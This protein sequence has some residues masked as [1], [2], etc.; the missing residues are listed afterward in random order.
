MR[1][2]GRD[3]IHFGQRKL[4]LLRQCRKMRRRQVTVAVL[5][6]PLRAILAREAWFQGQADK[7]VRMIVWLA[8][9]GH[10][11]A[12][13]ICLKHALPAGRGPGDRSLGA[14]GGYQR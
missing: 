14:A 3:L 8:T 7:M 1:I 2:E 13:R 11:A 9:G 5:D 12:M 10:P 4:H 6:D